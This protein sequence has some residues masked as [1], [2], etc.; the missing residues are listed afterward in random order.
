MN[1]TF[2]HADKPHEWN[3]AEW[4]AAIP[5]RAINRTR[6]HRAKLLPIEYFAENSPA[7][8]YACED[9]DV[10][11]MQRGA[12]PD[13][14]AAVEHWRQAGKVI[15]TDLD[16]GYPQI[17]QEHPAFE[18]WHRGISTDAMGNKARLPRPAILDMADGLRRVRGLTAPNRLI[19]SDWLDAVGIPGRY[20]PNYVPTKQYLN[21]VRTRSPGFDSTVWVAWGGSAGHLVSFTDS[22]ILYALARVIAKRPNVRFIMCGAD[23]RIIDALPLRLAQ[24]INLHWRPYR[25]WPERLV[26]FDI[27]LIPVAGD[28]DA[29]RSWLKPLE[30]SLCNVPWI[31][32][33]SPAYADLTGYGQF[34]DNTPDAWAAA[35]EDML[36]VGPDPAGLR[37]ARNWASAQDIDTNVEKIIDAYAELSK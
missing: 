8:A 1:V 18:F 28:F 34:V 24:K 9:A 6:K 35:I 20:V 13:T 36:A 2:V 12:M 21:A 16:D 19:L 3:S 29:R 5:A 22:G 26:N 32:S 31:A 27:G 30:Y 4:R 11:V 15:L 37:A 17:T 10:I 33:K 7:S 14:W 23:T 25:E